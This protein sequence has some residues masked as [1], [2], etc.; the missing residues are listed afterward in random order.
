MKANNAGFTLIELMFTII[1]LA[2]LLGVGLP[3][4]RDF[5]RNARLSSAANDLIAAVNLARSES[6]KR[7]V[8][9]S[10]CSRT[11]GGETCDGG[12]FST[13]WI[14]FAD[15]DGDGEV[16]DGDE[17]LKERGALADS[18]SVVAVTE[19]DPD[20]PGDWQPSAVSEFTYAP[21]GF[22]ILAGGGLPGDVAV[23]FCD[24]R[25][26]KVI[27]RSDEAEISAGR[28]VDVSMLGRAQVIRDA[29][30]IDTRAGCAK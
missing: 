19:P 29:G 3:N 11:E 30:E 23:T 14:V 20:E 13:G 21:S 7:R 26:N 6:I 5:I 9:V 22:R 27:A 12:N 16:D 17:V 18:I 1:V 15:T 25:L 28:V 8:P 4:F 2:V 10:V 24:D